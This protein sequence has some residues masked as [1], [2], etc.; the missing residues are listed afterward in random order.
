MLQILLV[1]STMQV[2]ND[3]VS[4]N[5]WDKSQGLINLYEMH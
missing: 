2:M 1:L 5:K 4:T 3:K